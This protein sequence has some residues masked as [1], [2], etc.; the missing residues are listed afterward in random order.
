MKISQKLLCRG[1]LTLLL[2]GAPFIARAADAP[3]P[4]PNQ[5]VQ[6]NALAYTQ[7]ELAAPI[8][9]GLKKKPFLK[10]ADT[11]LNASVGL[12]SMSGD[13]SL[14]NGEIKIAPLLSTKMAGAPALM[15][16]E[17]GYS[18]AL[19]R[20][21]TFTLAPDGKTLVLSGDQT[22]TF[23][24]T[25]QT[26][27]GFVLE[28]TV[29]LNV[30]PQLGAH[31]NGDKTPNYLQLEDLG[32][33]GWGRFT[34]DKILGFEFVPGTR[35][36]LRVAV[37]RD[38]RSGEKQLR[39]IEVLSQHFMDTA[40]LGKDDVIWEIAPTKVDCVGVAPMKCLQVREVG[41]TWKNFY[42]DIEGFNYVEGYRY[43]LQITVSKLA[44]PPADASNLRY[45]LARVLD[46]TPVTF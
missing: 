42:S 6:N 23:E 4:A 22:L 30:A 46:K 1:A 2:C 5:S 16:A 44:N 15:D 11:R 45:Q 40:T 41:G 12:N 21:R 17:N 38:Q 8:Y 24:L 32:Q 25:G 3:V 28:S 37:L 27:Q 31:M 34:Q 19:A 14:K 26:L 36:Q 33:V 29:I 13:Y 43:R 10:F 35:Y 18:Q 39:L 20:A 9:P 7:W